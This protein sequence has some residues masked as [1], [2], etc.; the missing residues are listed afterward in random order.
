MQ[1]QVPQNIDLEDKIIGSLTLKQ[2]IYLLVGGMLDYLF[3]R[4][5]SFSAFILLA[6]PTTIFFVAMALLRY[7]DQ[8]FPKFLA[9]LILFLIKPKRRTWGK[10]APL[11]KLVVANPPPE[12][13][14][15]VPKTITRSELEKLSEVVDTRGWGKR[16]ETL[17][18][19]ARVN[20]EER[21]KSQPEAKPSL[22]IRAEKVEDVLAPKG[23]LK[24]PPTEE[25]KE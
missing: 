6:L 14:K 15:A 7:Q 23:E 2:F 1:F 24:A 10:A 8:P 9:S 3:F 21:V 18:V 19:E 16:E 4:F 25:R 17:P 11:P 5:L 12:K 20:L 13:P 22:N